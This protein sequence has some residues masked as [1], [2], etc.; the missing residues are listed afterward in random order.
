MIE[1]FGQDGNDVAELWNSGESCAEIA[2]KYGVTRSTVTAGI[3]RLKARGLINRTGATIENPWTQQD[4]LT[5]TAMRSAGKTNQQIATVMG[6]SLGSVKAKIERMV[7]AGQ[8]KRIADMPGRP[9]TYGVRSFAFVK[10]DAA[11]VEEAIKTNKSLIG[12]IDSAM[13]GEG[14]PLLEIR[15]FRCRYLTGGAPEWRMCGEP[16]K[17]GSWCRKCRAIVYTRAA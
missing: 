10:R 9:K 14:T 4:D 8:L 5:L 6:R 3:Y 11:Q 7:Y 16:V 1:W 12:R 13:T 17:S 15:P 2:R